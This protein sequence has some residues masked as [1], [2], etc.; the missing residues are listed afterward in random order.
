MGFAA[1]R[2]FSNVTLGGESREKGTK[3]ITG[4]RILVWHS[5]NTATD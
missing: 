4:M 2:Y 5:A 3:V 1:G